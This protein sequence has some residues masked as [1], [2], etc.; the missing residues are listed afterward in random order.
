[1]RDCKYVYNCERIKDGYDLEF[2]YE[3]QLDQTILLRLQWYRAEEDEEQEYYS[4]FA[5]F[6]KAMELGNQEKFQESIFEEIHHHEGH[7]SEESDSCCV[8]YVSSDIDKSKLH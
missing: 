2:L 1:M 7:E 5:C 4:A 3:V 8:K 6:N